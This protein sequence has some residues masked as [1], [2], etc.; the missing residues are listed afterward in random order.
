MRWATASGRGLVSLLCQG[1]G[2]QAQINHRGPLITF[3]L[4]PIFSEDR[5]ESVELLQWL[6]I[7]RSS[8]MHVKA[9]TLVKTVMQ[10]TAECCIR[11][12]NRRIFSIMQR[13]PVGAPLENCVSDFLRCR[14]VK[15][16]STFVSTFFS[17]QTP[18]KQSLV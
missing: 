1:E 13:N 17:K 5:A 12:G 9:G 7:G 15:G 10:E 2:S 3:L 4:K 14:S 8:P 11:S 18:G 6:R 16:Y